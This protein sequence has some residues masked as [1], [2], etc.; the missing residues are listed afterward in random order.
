[1]YPSGS[2]RARLALLIEHGKLKVTI[3]KIYPSARIS[4]A[5]AYVESGHVNGKAVVTT[6]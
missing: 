6:T 2:E 3:D 4:E 1:M 5:L